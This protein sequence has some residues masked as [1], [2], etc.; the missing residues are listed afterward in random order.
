MEEYLFQSAIDELHTPIYNSAS[1]AHMHK[2]FRPSLILLV[3]FTFFYT[4]VHSAELTLDQ[5]PAKVFFSP[6][7]GCAKGIIKEIDTGTKE[8]LV[9]AYSFT[10]ISIRN[11]LINA[12]KRGVR[13]EII[14]DKNEQEEQHYRTAK[15]LAKNGIAVY[16]DGDHASAHNKVIIIDR[17][18]IVTGSFNFTLAAENKNAE[19]VL[20]I[21]SAALANL[22]AE[23]WHY[24]L[25]HSLRF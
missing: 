7:G 22:Y 13:V 4:S 3:F 2:V 14:F 17:E 5:A 20:I 24:H 16:T 11:A 25:K 10:S 18:T 8:I 9:S 21:R 1:E 15:A 23:N 6:K 19:N 12:R